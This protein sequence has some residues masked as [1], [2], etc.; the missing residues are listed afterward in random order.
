VVATG[1]T[2]P[3]TYLWSTGETTDCI[4]VSTTGTYSVTVTDAKGCVGTCEGS[5]TVHDLPVCRLECPATEVDCMSGG[6]TMT[7]IMD[8]EPAPIVDWLWTVDGPNWGIDGGNG[9]PTIT[10]HAGDA[11][12]CGLFEVTV[13]D[14]FG[15]QA[16]CSVECCCQ[17]G[18]YCTYT[19]GGWGSICPYER[20][21]N[22]THNDTLSTQPGCIRD[23]YWDRVYPSG[24]VCL[25]DPDGTDGGGDGFWAICWT[26][27]GA[28]RDFLPSGGSMEPYVPLTGDL[29]YNA[30]TARGTNVIVG[31]MLALKLNLDYSCARVFTDLGLLPSGVQCLYDFVIPDYEE[32]GGMFLGWTV[33]AFVAHADSIIGGALAAGPGELGA[34][35]GT[36]GCLNEYF[37]GCEAPAPTPMIPDTEAP[38]EPVI[39][40][41]VHPEGLV[42][43]HFDVSSAPNPANASATIHFAIPVGS[44]VTVEIFDIQGRRV[45]TLVNQD[46][47]AGYHTVVWSGKD[48]QGQTVATGVY[49]CRVQCCEGKE[50]L[51]KVIKIQ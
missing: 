11:A 13:T 41:D 15:C 26:S 1:G 18:G 35:G 51:K 5:V 9:T 44:K 39:Q 36:A 12:S 21:G 47:P 46:V 25:G 6:Y 2:A 37:H 34:I 3:Y 24:S 22:E 27:S 20:N 10:Y 28:V 33:G 40:P 31:Q 43:E 42:P 38:G 19:M 29:T 49:F 45:S 32:C 17:Y 30:G 23:W 50:L 16:T 8:Y 4:T 7:V 48:S 14:E